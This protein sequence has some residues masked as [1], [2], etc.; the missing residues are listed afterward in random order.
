MTPSMRLSDIIRR[1]SDT[2]GVE[3]ALNEAFALGHEFGLGRA[4]DFMDAHR[5]ESGIGAARKLRLL[6]VER[7]QVVAT[8]E[9][10]FL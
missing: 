10:D 6:E 3:D 4:A 8:R 9:E 1:W 2:P 7:V 5:G